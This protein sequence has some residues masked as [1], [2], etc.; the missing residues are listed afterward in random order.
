MDYCSARK[1]SEYAGS[2]HSMTSRVGVDAV[3]SGGPPN[4]M[5]P[6]VTVVGGHRHQQVLRYHQEHQ[7]RLA[8]LHSSEGLYQQQQQQHGFDRYLPSVSYPGDYHHQPPFGAAGLGYGS[9]GR[10]HVT[11]AYLNPHTPLPHH[12]YHPPHYDSTYN[13]RMIGGGGGTAG[14][15]SVLPYHPYRE[16]YDHQQSTPSSILHYAAA[17]RNSAFQYGNTAPSAA[18]QQQ[19]DYLQHYYPYHPTTTFMS[20]QRYG[21]HNPHSINGLQAVQGPKDDGRTTTNKKNAQH[22][23]ES[24]TSYAQQQQQQQ[25]N[26]PSLSSMGI[27]MIASPLTSGSTTTD[28][29]I[30]GS[31]RCG[32]TPISMVTTSAG[33]SGSEYSLN[34][35]SINAGIEENCSPSKEYNKNDQESI[36]EGNEEVDNA[37]SSTKDQQFSPNPPSSIKSS[38]SPH[39]ESE[40]TFSEKQCASN[41]RIDCPTPLHATPERCGTPF[42]SSNQHSPSNFQSP[43]RYQYAQ[44]K[45]SPNLCDTNEAPS[46]SPHQPLSPKAFSPNPNIKRIYSPECTPSSTLFEEKNKNRVVECDLIPS[47]KSKRKTLEAED[48]REEIRNIKPLPGFQQAFGSTEIGRFFET[49]RNIPSSPYAYESEVD[50]QSPQPW[51]I[52]NS[53]DG[54]QYDVQISASLQTMYK[55]P[56]ADKKYLNG[57]RCNGY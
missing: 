19:R 6:N 35:A 51:E 33:L 29:G 40:R 18:S 7:H 49:F 47:K 12:L 16:G 15:S 14:P 41:R 28:S 39:C 2:T 4:R 23:T 57:I 26:L 5:A 36:C 38:S 45:W 27:T 34:N 21:Q 8:A 37:V 54:S 44:K 1:Y 48:V 30:S 32:S 24:E 46:N 11:S 13:G 56:L 22:I 52:E 43:H 20:E 53:A 10:R 17:A 42:I 9:L 55:S 25:Q 3:L 50:N 31:S